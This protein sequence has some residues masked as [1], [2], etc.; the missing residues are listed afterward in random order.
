MSQQTNAAVYLISE[1]GVLRLG[2]K[3]PSRLGR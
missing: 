2:P 1:N 3:F